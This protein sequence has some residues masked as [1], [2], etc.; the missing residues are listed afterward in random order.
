M[1][2][3]Y[4]LGQDFQPFRYYNE[5]NYDTRNSAARALEKSTYFIR[6]RIFIEHG[7]YLV[8]FGVMKY[9][10]SSNGFVE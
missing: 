9:K 2:L 6:R 1:I 7:E 4:R 10:F 3:V 5:M 8:F